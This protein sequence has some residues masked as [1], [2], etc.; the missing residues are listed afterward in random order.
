MYQRSGLYNATA[1]PA[2]ARSPAATEPIFF[3]AAPVKPAAPADPVFDGATG[4]IGE[5]VAAAPDPEPAPEPEAAPE[6][7][8]ELDPE[9]PVGKAAVP[10]ANPVE[11][12]TTVELD[13]CN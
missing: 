13:E 3:V 11:P 1:I 2:T 8:P 4:A 5:P 6:P 10:V 9:V 12:G 7:E